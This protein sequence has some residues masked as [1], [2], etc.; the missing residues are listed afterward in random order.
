MT[1]ENDL[2][3]IK[4]KSNVVIRWCHFT[5]LESFDIILPVSFT[6]I[7]QNS[8]NSQGTKTILTC[9]PAQ[10]NV[11]GTTCGPIIRGYRT[12]GLVHLLDGQDRHIWPLIVR[13]VPMK[14]G[15][16][17]SPLT[18]WDLAVSNLQKQ[19]SPITTSKIPHCL[20]QLEITKS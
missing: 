6:P 3:I 15:C 13:Q 8:I 9:S 11:N 20:P 18:L 19:H 10:K 1:F 2:K 4:I 17:D 14:A 16:S 7:P 5:S 12:Q